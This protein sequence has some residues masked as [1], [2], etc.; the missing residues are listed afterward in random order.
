[1]TT[2]PPGPTN[3]SMITIITAIVTVLF[4]AGLFW[5]AC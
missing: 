1:M 5:L 4:F 2:P 3:Y